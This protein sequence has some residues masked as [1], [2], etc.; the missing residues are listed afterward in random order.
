[1]DNAESI[2][3]EI[4]TG[5]YN[6]IKS[7]YKE[8]WEETVFI[9]FKRK[10]APSIEGAQKS[11]RSIYSE[12]LSGFSN[13]SGGV[14]V[15]G[16]NAPGLQGKADVAIDEEPIFHLKR[17]LTDLNNATS[18]VLVPINSG[19]V[20][21]PIYVND[22]MACDKGFII[23][24]IP[25]SELTPHRAINKDHK[26]FLRSGDSFVMMEHSILE[27]QFGKR[28]RPKLKVYARLRK[29]V[30]Y[31]K[32]SQS[33]IFGIENEG[34]YIAKAP[35]IKINVGENLEIRKSTETRNYMAFNLNVV[36]FT[37]EETQRSGVFFGGDF[38]KVIYPG[39]H[40]EVSIIDITTLKE[41][42]PYNHLVSLEDSYFE[43]IVE[44]MIYAENLMPVSG[45]WTMSAAHLIDELGW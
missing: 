32:A 12:A 23:T 39:T 30:P 16:I 15:W 11:D 7:L 27:D 2:Y 31:D 24:L 19:V 43:Y 13:T 20:N 44:Y 41:A 25:Q 1:M 10:A 37:P 6:K 40:M 3:N 5:G 33:I 21:T 8:Q 36:S 9:D 35:A 38:N 22:D 28:Q 17:F 45:T 14:I 18:Q 34:R 29:N 42:D 26:Y 4:I